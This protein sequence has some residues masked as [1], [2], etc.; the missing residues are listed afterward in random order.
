[1]QTPRTRPPTFLE[2]RGLRQQARTAGLHPDYWYAVEHSHALRRG[3]VQ[4]VRF[5]GRS[6]ALYRGQDGVVRALE[7]RCA[8]RRLKLSHGEVQGCNLTCIYHGWTYAPDGT[9]ISFAHELFGKPMPTFRI[10]SFPVR[11][12]YGLIWLFPGDPAVS[13]TRGIPDIPE[14]EGPRRWACVPI[15]LRLRCHHSM[16][17]ENI[18]DFTHAYLHRKTRP[19]IDAKLTRY[20]AQP[21]RVVVEYD[22][23]V[24]AGPIARLFV[25][26]KRVRT[27]HMVLAYEYPYQWSNTGD[28]IKS[29][30]FVLPEDESHCRAFFLFY[31]DALKIPFTSVPIPQWLLTYVLKVA[32]RVLIG[33]ILAE[34]AFAVEAE[35]EGWELHHD[36]PAAELNPAMV[37]FQQLTVR[38]WQEY[39]EAASR[40]SMVKA[41][42][43]P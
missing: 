36:A 27:D 13:A 28:R 37:E 1:M 31:F 19:F 23:L 25:D 20:E 38:R 41:Q 26:R 34:D 14:L 6:F 42:V 39:L 30:C 43:Q 5:W 4:E 2:A 29:W 3:Q 16:L 21:E 32:N 33:P 22:T 15:S 9:V 11:E 18:C 12:R 35:Q 17:I 24:G 40:R 10:G 8:H 7:N